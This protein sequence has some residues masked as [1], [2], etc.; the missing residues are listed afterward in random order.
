[1]IRRRL[2]RLMRS[3]RRAAIEAETWRYYS[4]QH[5]SVRRALADLERAGL[6]S[7]LAYS[8]TAGEPYDWADDDDWREGA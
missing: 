2:L 3:D 7:Q 6:L 1:M 5:S 4:E 8:Q